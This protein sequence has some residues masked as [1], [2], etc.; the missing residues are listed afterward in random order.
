MPSCWRLALSVPE[1]N[2]GLGIWWWLSSAPTSAAAGEGNWPGCCSLS[3]SVDIGACCPPSTAG[4]GPPTGTC[5]PPSS[6]GGGLTTGARC[7]TSPGDCSLSL[8]AGH[9]WGGAG[10]GCFTGS[11]SFLPGG[12]QAC[13][14]WCLSSGESE[15][16]P[17]GLLWEVAES[18]DGCGSSSSSFRSARRCEQKVFDAVVSRPPAFRSSAG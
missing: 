15:W 10:Q 7:S 12:E 18:E 13:W 14:A 1:G 8:S 3:S 6:L 4:R 11:D 9:G 16:D 17:A 5:C 2:V